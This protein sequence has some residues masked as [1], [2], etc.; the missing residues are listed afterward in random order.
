MKKVM[1]IFVLFFMASYVV[2]AQEDEKFIEEQDTTTKVKPVRKLSDKVV[3][4]GNF[5]LCFGSITNIMLSPNIGYKVLPSL[6]CGVSATYQYYKNSA[7]NYQENILGASVFS[8]FHILPQAFL[9]AEIEELYYK[10]DGDVNSGGK[11][12]V[13][14]YLVGGGYRQQFGERAA[15]NYM[16]LWNLNETSN[17]IYSNPIIRVSF[18]F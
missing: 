2:N 13:D 1:I 3:L 11:R 14:S 10:Y 9:H 6:V 15:I 8:Q 17:S 12:W 18:N 16:I 4:G 7:Y 5:G